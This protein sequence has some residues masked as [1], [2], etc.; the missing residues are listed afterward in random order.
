MLNVCIRSPHSESPLKREYLRS[1]K[2]ISAGQV[3]KSGDAPGCN[4][5]QLHDDINVSS[6]IQRPTL[7]AVLKWQAIQCREDWDQTNKMSSN[8][9]TFKER[10]CTA[11][12]FLIQSEPIKK[13]RSS[14]K[15]KNIKCCLGVVALHIL[16]VFIYQ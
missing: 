11:F 1:A 10:M 6:V 3:F 15:Q 13:C 8:S 12:I 5:L 14:Y 7:D 2:T 4:F 9:K 16:L